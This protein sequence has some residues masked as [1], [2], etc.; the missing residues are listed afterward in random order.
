M[1]KKHQQIP[2]ID[3]VADVERSALPDKR[4]RRRAVRITKALMDTPDKGFP[5]AMGDSASLEGLYRFVENDRLEFEALLS[6]HVQGT[7]ERIQGQPLVVVA[8]D[9]TQYGFSN[10][11][12]R[13]GLGPMNRS[14]T[15][16]FF[17]HTALAVLP[18]RRPDVFGVLGCKPWAR[19][20]PEESQD[21]PI[22][23]VSEDAQ[24][25]APEAA[26]DA[27][28]GVEPSA[29]KTS[30]LKRRL[31]RQRFHDEDKESLRWVA[32]VEQVEKEVAQ[33][34]PEAERPVLIHVMDREADSYEILADQEQKR[35]RFVIRS[36]YDRRV[37]APSQAPGSGKLR[38]VLATAMVLATRDGI[39]VSRRG[40]NRTQR[41]IKR[42]PV[43]GDRIASVQ[44]CAQSVTL[45]RP[46]DCRDN[47]PPTLQVNVVHVHEVNTPEGEEPIEWYLYT[48]E[49]IKTAE[50]VLAVVDFYLSRWTVEE[51]FKA[52][53]TG[54]A[55]EKR[56]LESYHALLMALALTIPIACSLLRLRTLADLSEPVAA[57]E[58]LSLVQIHIL[59]KKASGGLP[60]MPT[61]KQAM[62]AIAALGGH[63]RNNGAPGWQVLGRGYE[64][65]R[66][67]EEGFLLAK[68]S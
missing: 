16:G 14:G 10:E 64:K 33:Q 26:G 48:S 62:M 49:P 46:D 40:K 22:S 13:D 51:Y 47:W 9:T 61:V 30:T 59:R 67:L 2:K 56:Q 53:K 55:F 52:V 66:S 63:I 23:G 57:S 21:A 8:H 17:D 37:M 68:S 34:L 27:G 32:M 60:R 19:S 28:D 31:S 12:P 35:R 15:Q 38:G 44:M 45:V 58:V 36:T 7:C 3:P 18:G 11:S 54:C 39:K 20:W 1:T 24:Q 4:H 25:P 41:K 6:G 65:L 42:F 43:R 5:E 29:T 50:D